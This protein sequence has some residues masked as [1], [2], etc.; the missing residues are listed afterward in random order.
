MRRSVLH[1]CQHDPVTTPTEGMARLLTAAARGGLDELLTRHGVRV[2]TVFG[3]TGRGEPD[4]RDLD[5]GV[6]FDPGAG[7]DA[8][9]LAA[10]LA[11]LTGSAVDLGVVDHA[12]AV[13]RERALAEATPV[14]EATPGAWI[15]ASVVATLERMDTA[16]LRR[17][18]LER[19]ASA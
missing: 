6:L 17:A 1:P 12:T 10:D 18:D 15:E 19:R 11:E 13:F 3:S 9:A 2:L 16:W 7:G 5:V 8:L 14:W 4:P